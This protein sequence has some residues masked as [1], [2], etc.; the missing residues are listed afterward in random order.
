MEVYTS[1]TRNSK[2]IICSAG[3]HFV[4]GDLFYLLVIETT[5]DMAF[6]ARRGGDRVSGRIQGGSARGGH[7]LRGRSGLPSRGP[8]GVN[9]RPSARTIAKARPKLT[10]CFCSWSDSRIK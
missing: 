3:C 2:V 5:L 9:T 6:Y 8:L 4:V 10:L 7:V 1:L